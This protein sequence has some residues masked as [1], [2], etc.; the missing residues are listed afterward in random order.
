MHPLYLFSGGC[1]TSVLIAGIYFA[2]IVDV[3]TV[4]LT[5]GWEGTG[6]VFPDGVTLRFLAISHPPVAFHIT[7][8]HPHYHPYKFPIRS[9]QPCKAS[10]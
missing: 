9:H 1:S 5:V 3:G 7:S 10:R 4:V 6:A 8:P 2:V